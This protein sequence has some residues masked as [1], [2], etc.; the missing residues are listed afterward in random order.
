M[1]ISDSKK[2]LAV[3]LLTV[4]LLPFVINCFFAYPQT[5]D[6]VYSVAARSLGFLTCQYDWYVKWSGRFTSTVLLSI[7]PLVHDSLAGYRLSFALLIAAQVGSLYLLTHALTKRTLAWQEK[8]AFSLALLFACLDQ[9]DDLRSWLYWM[10]GVATYQVAATM[11]VL[12][13]SLILLMDQD[14]KFDNLW[15]RGAVLAL[16]LFLGGTN[17]IV[18]SLTFLFS[19][20]L[21][22]YRYASRKTLTPFHIATF[23]AVATGSC[24]GV[25][26][27]GNFA[28]MKSDYDTHRTVWTIAWN[29]FKAALASMEVWM[30]YPVTL[31]LVTAVFCTVI[32]RPQLRAIYGRI[33]ILYSMCMLL[34]LVVLG[35]FIPYWATGMYPQN[36]VLNI[37]YFFFMIGLTINVAVIFS[38]LGEPALAFLKNIPSKR[39][40]M[41]GVVF[42][43]VLF[44]LQRSNFVTV[45]KDLLS[46][47][48]L[49]YSREMQQKQSQLIH[50]ATSHCTTSE[51]TTRPAS[52]YF[53]FI[54]SDPQNWVN[55]AYAA[56]FGK[57]SVSLAK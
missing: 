31:I 56:Y 16:S 29:A 33:R 22:A 9:M 38:K 46:G 34:L 37:I 8:L 7:N 40:S 51:V 10:A 35:F 3:L 25:F 5:D 45:T 20:T 53:Y 30:T 41:V 48:S 49:R 52:L 28:R 1:P 50:C 6:F 17:E 11:M 43:A 55:R 12:W 26:A 57:E 32:S 13:L 42:L 2:T 36:R 27:P 54:D 24:I 18:L 23:F 14:Q 15:N 44:C 39:C 47:D 4:L 19:L 21:I